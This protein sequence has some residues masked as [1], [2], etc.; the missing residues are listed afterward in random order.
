MLAT[1]TPNPGPAT[2][3]VASGVTLYNLKAVADM[4]C[5]LSVGEFEDDVPF[6]PKRYFLVFDVPSK[7]VRGEHAHRVCHQFLICVNGEIAVVADNGQE[8]QELLL[9]R[10]SLGLHV[11]PMVW[12][13]QYKYSKDAVLLVFASESYDPA[14]YIRDYDEFTRLIVSPFVKNVSGLAL[15]RAA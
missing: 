13:T 7:H 3:Q 11:P 10:P 14:D 1:T 4:R 8:R 15:T 6:V 2:Q 12:C 9:D 5:M